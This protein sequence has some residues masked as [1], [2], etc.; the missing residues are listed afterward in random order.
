MSDESCLTHPD[1]LSILR[2]PLCVAELEEDTAASV[3]RCTVCGR[4]YPVRE[5]MPVM[6][7]EEAEPHA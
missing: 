2:C 1:L 6:L 3:L 4:R 7:I 5:G